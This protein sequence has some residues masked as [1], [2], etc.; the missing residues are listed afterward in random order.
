[1]DDF[2][3]SGIFYV[4]VNQQ[5]KYLMS[6]VS[7]TVPAIP[8]AILVETAPP[9]TNHYWDGADWVERAVQ[10][11]LSHEFDWETKVWVDPRTLEQHKFIAR[12]KLEVSRNRRAEAPIEFEGATL[13]ADL[14]SQGNIKDKL[15]DI[16]Q[17]RKQGLDYPTDLL[18]WRDYDNLMH[19]FVTVDEY[20]GWLSRLLIA[21]AERGTRTY[22]WM[23]GKKAEVDACGSVNGLE[24]VDLS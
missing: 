16:D 11:S 3:T 17:R 6:G 20:E 24:A 2:I 23:W 5:G 13:D 12:G 18:F 15:V 9:S 8:D 21:I 1:M 14:K 22:L 7:D 10:P 4:L 19:T